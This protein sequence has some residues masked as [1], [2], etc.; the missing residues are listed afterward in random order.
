MKVSKN[1]EDEPRI[2]DTDCTQLGACLLSK[3][4]ENVVLGCARTP[5]KTK[6]WDRIHRRE[7]NRSPAQRELSPGTRTP[8]E[9][10]KEMKECTGYAKFEGALCVQEQSQEG[11]SAM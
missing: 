9:N 4:S 7:T 1:S 3:G 5:G 10:F 6:R 11:S 8:E 2:Q